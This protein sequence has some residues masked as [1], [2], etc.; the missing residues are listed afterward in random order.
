ML[1]WLTD[2]TVEY[3]SD[4]DES[5]S[6]SEKSAKGEESLQWDYFD[7]VPKSASGVLLFYVFCGLWMLF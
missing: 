6:E 3:K 1:C 7:T 5:S 2:E 4:A